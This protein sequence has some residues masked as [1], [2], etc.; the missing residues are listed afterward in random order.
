[1]SGT[2][3]ASSVAWVIVALTAACGRTEYQ[4]P[5]IIDPAARD[6]TSELDGAALDGAALDGA[7]LDGAALDGAALDGAALDGGASSS[8]AGASDAAAG[9]DAP[10]T[11][12]GGV[13]ACATGD[14]V[15]PVTVINASPVDPTFA[16]NVGNALGRDDQV[17][18][19]DLAAATELGC[20]TWDD[21]ADGGLDVGGC[22]CIAVD[23]GGVAPIAAATIRVAARPLACTA[24]CVGARCGTGR[25]LTAWAGTEI[26]AY[27]FVS[28]VTVTDVLTDYEVPIARD[29]RYVVLCRDRWAA[30]ADD[31]VVDDVVARCR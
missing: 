3:P 11:D 17:A 19:L 13:I 21:G 29:V 25:Q 20:S 4:A 26:G 16:C 28:K 5:R 30:E 31:I 15:A 23:L 14:I 9:L 6:A 7:A 8:E 18:G 24:T 1:M 2:A 12:D 10:T 27:R 22:G